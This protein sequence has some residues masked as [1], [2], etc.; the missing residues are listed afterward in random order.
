MNTESLSRKYKLYF[1]SFL[2]ISIFSSAQDTDKLAKDADKCIYLKYLQLDDSDFK[3]SFYK[4][5][6]TYN[7]IIKKVNNYDNEEARQIGAGGIEIMARERDQIIIRI[8]ETVK[9]FGACN[10]EEEKYIPRLTTPD[11]NGKVKDVGDILNDKDVKN[12]YFNK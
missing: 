7:T 5:I 4:N 11:Q 10:V 9:L 12:W 3:N 2:L 1:V 6:D 8:V